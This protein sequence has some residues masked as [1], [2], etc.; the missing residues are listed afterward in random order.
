MNVLA[1]TR[2]VVLHI[3][4]AWDVDL[5]ALRELRRLVADEYGAQLE[6]RA[7]PL[8]SDPLIDLLGHW[9]DWTQHEVE[10]QVSRLVAPT[11]FTLDWLDEV[12]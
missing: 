8:L 9:D 6:L 5:L 10:Q 1:G 7:Q 4:H 3:S 11:F 12:D 2:T